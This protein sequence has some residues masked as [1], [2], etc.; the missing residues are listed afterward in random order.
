MWLMLL[1][2]PAHDLDGG[3]GIDSRM[4]VGARSRGHRGKL[5]EKAIEVID[6]MRF[7]RLELPAQLLEL[8]LVY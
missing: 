1:A 2:D 6:D 4:H 8:D 3:F 5:L 7:G